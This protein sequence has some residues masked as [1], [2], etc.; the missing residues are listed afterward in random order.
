MRITFVT[1]AL[2]TIGLLAPAL[3]AQSTT[4]P[5]PYT[6]TVVHLGSYD[7]ES[8]TITPANPG[9]DGV[10]SVV[11]DNTAD[12]G[13]FFSPGPGVLSMDW[14]VLS[15]GGAN[16]IATIQIGYATQTIGTVDIGVRIH[17]GATGF[18][19]GGTVVSN[20]LVSGLPGSA[21]G[22][23]VAFTLDIDLAGA[24]LSFDLADGA[25]GY[26][27][28]T[29]DASTGPL[30]VGPPNEAGVADAFDQ[31]LSGDGSYLGT[32]FFGGAP[33]ASFHCRLAGVE[34]ECFLLLGLD[35]LNLPMF[36]KAEDL[37]L[38]DFLVFWPV[39]YETMP[40]FEVPNSPVLEGIDL[41]WQVFMH[42]AAVFPDDPIQ[43][44]NGIR[45]TL[46]SPS[47]PATY[48][49]PSTIDFWPNKPVQLGGEID[50]MFSI[51]GL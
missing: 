4:T 24:G 40:V 34:P 51:Q 17:E 47:L 15:A 28:E 45:T 25:I 43:L 2:L 46:G 10:P 19:G 30:L 22:E 13:F 39:T 36:G 8:H 42:N 31:Y 37:L 20:V 33:F 3:L 9:G 1:R 5:I 14:G 27:Y 16:T 21:A 38:V 7:L 11:Y 29:F 48:G 50:M 6:G 32:F 49:P 23:V 35:T 44:S 12:N 41:Y 18:S 26:S